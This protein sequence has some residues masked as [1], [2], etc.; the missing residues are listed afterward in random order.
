MYYQT[1]TVLSV[2]ADTTFRPSGLNDAEVT[3]SE[4]PCSVCSHSPVTASQ[5]RTV[6][7]V[8]PDTTFVPSGLNDAD[9]T[10]EA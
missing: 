7:S 2:L 10:V 3:A 8:L 4:C 9:V 6:L 1:R 5:I